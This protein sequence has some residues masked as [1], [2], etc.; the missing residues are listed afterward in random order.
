MCEFERN[1]MN[2]FEAE[3]E[4]DYEHVWNQEQA[5]NYYKALFGESDV[6]MNKVTDRA[7]YLAKQIKNVIEPVTIRRNSSRFTK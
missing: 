5:K 2:Q 4:Y 6:D 1:M 3:E 7:H